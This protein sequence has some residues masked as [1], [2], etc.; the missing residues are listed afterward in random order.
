MSFPAPCHDIFIDPIPCREVSEAP[1]R[2][3]AYVS[4]P[5]SYGY[6][7]FYRV[8]RE[9]K[10]LRHLQLIPCAY[11]IALSH[12]GHSALFQKRDQRKRPADTSSNTDSDNAEHINTNLSCG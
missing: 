8:C 1:L 6:S 2:H 9:L 7:R 12:L 3:H 4:S 11:F 10:E 5:D